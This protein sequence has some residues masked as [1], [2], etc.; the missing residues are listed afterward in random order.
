MAAIVA[1]L[2]QNHI[3]GAK[4]GEFRDWDRLL[5]QAGKSS[6]EQS[7][8]YGDAVAA[9]HGI[10]VKRR[11]IHCGDR[12]VALV[13]G[14]RTRDLKFGSIN[15]ILRGPVWLQ[16]LS[17]EQCI[18]ICRL[19]R[20]EF[21]KR[22]ADLLFWLPEL[23]D[24]PDSMRLMKALG[25]R[26]MVTGYSTVWLDIRPDEDSLLDGLHG[27]WRNSLRTAEKA[28]IRVRQATRDKAFEKSMA[29]Y[30]RFRRNRKFIGPPANLIRYIL[31]AP[32]PSDK[33]GNVRV[34]EAIH[35]NKPVAGIAVIRHGASATYLAGWTGED[36]RHRNAHN[37][38]LWRAIAKLRETGTDWLD[39]GG[40]DTQTA[41]GIARFK[42]GLGGELLTTTGTY[43]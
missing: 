29:T 26:R 10:E 39:L 5:R 23:P 12:P 27:K 28:G 17:P 13:Q 42:L 37:I 6:L 41:P 16:D 7:W 32:R 25:M 2:S 14:F 19:I 35:D 4:P 9:L 40:V 3:F 1:A 38:L 20:H 34:W 33:T 36:G 24:T 18:E 8:Q 15:R 31:S 22:I 11:I 21:H 30:D 43:L